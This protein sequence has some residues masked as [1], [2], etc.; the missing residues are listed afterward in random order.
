MC[1]ILMA[2]FYYARATLYNLDKVSE[3]PARTLVYAR[4]G[5]TELG[6]LHGDNRYIVHHDQVSEYFKHALI[7]RED[8]H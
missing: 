4:D 6:R 2:A 7:S 5:K 8:A 3:M 1:F